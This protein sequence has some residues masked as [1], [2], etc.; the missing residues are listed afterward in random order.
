MKRIPLLLAG[1]AFAAL[2]ASAPAAQAAHS[3]LFHT[4]E[5]RKVKGT[6]VL[7]N[8]AGSILYEF[9]KD[10]P[11][12]DTCVKISGCST[13][14][15]PMPVEGKPSA[16]AG[17]RASQLS[18]IKLPEGISQVTYAGH[19][20]YIYDAAPT[21]A[22]YIGAKQFGGSWYAVS[23]SRQGGQVNA[24]CTEMPRICD[25]RPATLRPRRNL[26]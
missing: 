24:S 11:K 8:S 6:K 9:T 2:A 1:A 25:K 10:H 7:V 16:G 19:P 5:L 4:V 13:V 3:S 15:T 23:A 12:K 22:S 20:L 17:V 18:T 21:L 26:R 14:W